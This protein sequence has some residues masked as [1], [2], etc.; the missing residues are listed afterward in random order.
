VLSVYKLPSVNTR[1]LEPDAPL[2]SELFRRAVAGRLSQTTLHAL[3]ELIVEMYRSLVTSKSS[4]VFLG[5]VAGGAA[6]PTIGSQSIPELRSCFHVLSRRS[7][8]L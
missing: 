7:T 2:L 5:I 1:S 3:K 4:Q 8:G 6:Y